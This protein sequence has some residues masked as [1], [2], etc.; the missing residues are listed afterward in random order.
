M[1]GRLIYRLAHQE[2]LAKLP[3][4]SEIPQ[5]GSRDGRCAD[6]GD[7]RVPYADD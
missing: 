6:V 1:D 5:P 7:W 4:E 2:I 3:A